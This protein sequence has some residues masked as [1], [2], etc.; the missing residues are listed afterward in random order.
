MKKI[1]NYCYLCCVNNA[2]SFRSF[3]PLSFA[4]QRFLF[5][6]VLFIVEI[7]PY[8]FL[9]SDNRFV[10]RP[11][12]APPAV[13]RKCRSRRRRPRKPGGRGGKRSN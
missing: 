5:S 8:S 4:G 10:C 9:C 7:D 12:Y 2:S 1:E 13:K 11:R 6:P 3:S